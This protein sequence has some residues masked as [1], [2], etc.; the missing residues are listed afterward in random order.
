MLHYI[1][2]CNQ[3]EMT[4][5]VPFR[6]NMT[7]VNLPAKY[8][9]SKHNVLNFYQNISI[10]DEYFSE[11]AVGCTASYFVKIIWSP[12]KSPKDG[13]YSI[14]DDFSCSLSNEVVIIERKYVQ[15]EKNEAKG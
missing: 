9:L 14:T 13:C 11:T 8:L 3:F 1:L 7:C 4:L 6:N 2:K 12:V 10:S 5:F 15:M